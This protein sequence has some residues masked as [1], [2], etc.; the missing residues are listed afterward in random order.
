MTREEF[1]YQL[2][3]VADIQR[4]EGWSERSIGLYAD[5]MWALTPDECLPC[6]LMIG[7]GLAQDN[8]RFGVYCKTAF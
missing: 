5:E 6:T 1:K 7:A 8:S 2:L 3:V 4:R